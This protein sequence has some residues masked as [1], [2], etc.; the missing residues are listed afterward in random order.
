MTL[1]EWLESLSY[2]VTILGLPGAIAVFLYQQRKARQNEENELHGRLSEEYDGF[3]RLVLE[4]ADLQLLRRQGAPQ[5]QLSAEQE[6]RKHIIFSILIS[7]FEKAYIILY[8]QNMSK[9]TS[10]MW[11]SW[12]DDM[13]EWCQREDFR[14]EL[15]DLLEGEDDA[16]SQHIITIAEHQ[17]H[18]A[19]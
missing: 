16:F 11:S 18:N 1:L 5:Q 9:D 10:R 4:N 17:A 8:N 15:P 3:L 13:H 7:L 6:E 14:T 2:V 19:G 12:E